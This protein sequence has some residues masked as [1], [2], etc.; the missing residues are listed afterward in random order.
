MLGG[1][2]QLY[3]PLVNHPQFGKYDLSG[4][5]LAASGAA[6]LA[7]SVLDRMMEAF[8]GVVCE[9]YGL[10]ECTMC[11]TANPPSRTAMKPGSVG[12]PIFDTEVRIADLVTGESLPAPEEGEVC[13]RG[14]QVMRGYWGKPEETAQTMA[15]GWLR[16]GDIGRMDE[17]GYLYITDRKKDMIIYKG[18]NVYP[19]EL[20]EILFQ[21]PSVEQCAVVG[22]EEIEVGEAPVAFVK[23]RAGTETSPELLRDHVNGQVAHYKKIR[24]VLLTEQIPVSAAGKVLKKELRE[25]LRKRGQET[26]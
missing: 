24:E 17:E 5:K 15:D 16:T 14:P 7:R 1:A 8:S 23:L 19:R 11:A 9:A 18:Y 10:S 4:I 26:Q 25:F 22:K 2:P 12:L 3:I 21:H 20:E 6:P 13:I